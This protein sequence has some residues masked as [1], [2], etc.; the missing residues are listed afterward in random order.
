MNIFYSS[1]FLLFL[2]K[3][4]SLKSNQ[5]FEK[6]VFSRNVKS[7][8]RNAFLNFRKIYVING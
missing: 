1:F 2:K 6:S 3:I 7:H 5:N 8:F 4:V